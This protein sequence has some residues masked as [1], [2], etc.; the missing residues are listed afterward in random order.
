MGKAGWI[1]GVAWYKS[2]TLRK[3]FAGGTYIYIVL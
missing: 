3:L 1:S 2:V